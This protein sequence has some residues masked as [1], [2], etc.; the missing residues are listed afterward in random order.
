[1]FAVVL[2]AVGVAWSIHLA[3]FAI[4]ICL[5]GVTAELVSLVGI[6]PGA[7]CA[8]CRWV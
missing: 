8:G 2:I 6:G 7:G 5:V 4:D 3:V 1:M